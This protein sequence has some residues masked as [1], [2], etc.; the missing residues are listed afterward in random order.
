M[1][2]MGEPGQSSHATRGL[3]TQVRD[4]AEARGGKKNFFWLYLQSGREVALRCPPE[5]EI[6]GHAAGCRVFSLPCS[7]CCKSDDGDRCGDRAGPTMGDPRQEG[8][9]PRTWLEGGGQPRVSE[10]L[11][12]D[13]AFKE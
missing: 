13:S 12:V 7:K 9:G 4:T 1:P 8:T 6:R 2:G 3:D 5:A 10:F 11:L